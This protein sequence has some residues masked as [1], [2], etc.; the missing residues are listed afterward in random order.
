M[1]SHPKKIR[2]VEH[3]DDEARRD[4]F[5]RKVADFEV[6]WGLGEE[7]WATSNVGG[8]VAVP[9]WPEAEFAASCA[10]DEWDGFRAKPIPLSEFLSKWL[11]GMDVDQRICLIFPTPASRGLPLPADKL[12]QFIEEE[13]QQYE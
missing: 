11:P 8:V 13:L 6:V 4:Y 3:L 7:G 1:P 10:V 12:R 9:F 2:N 5:V